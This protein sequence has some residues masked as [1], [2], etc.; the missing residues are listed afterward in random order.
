MK[1]FVA[2]KM[3]EYLVPRRSERVKILVESDDHPFT[4]LSTS[5]RTLHHSTRRR[6]AVTL[7]GMDFHGDGT[8]RSIINLSL[9]QLAVTFA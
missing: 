8:R 6:A 1:S 4:S 7:Q 5:T 3:A 9:P 2:V